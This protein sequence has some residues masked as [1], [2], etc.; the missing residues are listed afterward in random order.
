MATGRVPV[1]LDPEQVKKAC[2]DAADMISGMGYHG[3]HGSFHL[4]DLNLQANTVTAILHN[5]IAWQIGAS[6]HAG[7]SARK[8]AE[9]RT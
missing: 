8:V 2:L 1:D 7:R 9:R 3:S 6:I 4:L 5:M